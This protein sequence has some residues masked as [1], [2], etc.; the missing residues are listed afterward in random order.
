MLRHTTGSIV[1]WLPLALAGCQANSP[2][3]GAESI[4]HRPAVAASDPQ[5][6]P[7]NSTAQNSAPKTP[8]KITDADKPGDS[9]RKNDNG[10]PL[11]KSLERS[12]LF[13]PT[14][15][16]DGDWQPAGLTFEDSAFKAADGTRLHGWFVPHERP[17]AVVLFAHGNGG[18]LSHRAG[19]LRVLHDSL[20]VAV[21]I[22]DYR[23]YGHSEGTADGENILADARAARAWLVE[24]TGVA[25]DKL[26]LMGESLGGAVAVDLASADGARGL[27][28]D[29][30]FSSLPEVAA[31]HYPWAPTSLMHTRLDSAAKIV[32]YHGPLIEFHGDKDRTIPIQFGRKLFEAANEP[33]QFVL[34]SGRDHNDA[35]PA[36]FFEA[37]DRYF[38]GLP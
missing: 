11:I 29:S 31:F 4:S 23:G 3:P 30:T 5:P 37:L 28:L 38:A 20:G 6:R 25:P 13:F 34:L 14:R 24:R 16:P 27:I 35:R 21:M 1:V 32:R 7:T 26:V 36:E 9:V 33:K 12:L 19:L 15:F 22:F 8:D 17:R 18:N 2:R 10:N